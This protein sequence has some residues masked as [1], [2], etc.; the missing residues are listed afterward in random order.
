MGNIWF[1]SDTH[2]QHTNMLKFLGEDGL[3]F[4]GKHFGSQEECD[5]TMIQNWNKVI[6]PED[7]VWHLGDVW[8]GSTE[9]YMEKIHPR[10]MGKKRVIVGNHDDIRELCAKNPFTGEW[11]FQKVEVWRVFRGHD[12]IATHVPMQ[13]DHSYE[14]RNMTFNVHGHIHNNRAPTLRHY[15]ACVEVNDWA[16]IHIEDLKAKLNKRKASL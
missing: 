8:M 16:P 14:G 7:T 15:N 6:R 4:R 12:F 3:P 1:I 2:F 5:E 13:M 11:M 10:L 9:R